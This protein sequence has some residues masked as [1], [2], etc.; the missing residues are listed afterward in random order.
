MWRAST[1][2]LQIQYGSVPLSYHRQSKMTEWVEVSSLAS[3]T[4]PCVRPTVRVLLWH[5]LPTYKIFVVSNLLCRE[6]VVVIVKTFRT[7]IITAS[8]A[9]LASYSNKDISVPFKWSL[10]QD[11]STSDSW[12]VALYSLDWNFG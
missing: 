11:S 6:L 1:L 3:S 2:R 9:C 12:C 7:V 4:Y 5:P 10:F 8:I